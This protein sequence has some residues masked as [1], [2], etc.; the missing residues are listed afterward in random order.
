MPQTVHSKVEK[1]TTSGVFSQKMADYQLLVK[2][3]LNLWVVF[4]AVMGYLAAIGTNIDLG[5]LLLLAIGGFLVTGASN[6][7][8]QVLEREYDK[9]MKRTANRPL[10]AGRMSVTEAVFAA[11]WMSLVGIGCLSF[12]NPLTGFLGM[13]SLISYAFIYTPMKRM[14]PTAVAVGAFPGALPAAIG[15]VA[16]DGYLSQLAIL[17]FVVQFLW[18]FP[19]FWAIGWVGDEDYKN[20]GFNLMP[21][22]DGKL[23]ASIG[24]QSWAICLLMAVNAAIG[25]FLG[26]FGIF[27]T[28]VVAGMSLG[29]A[30]FGWK[31]QIEKSRKAA[32]GQMF[33]SFVY[34]PV[35]LIA[36]Y[37]DKIF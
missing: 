3:K 9:Q 31:L 16:V 32:L 7:L 8:N 18:Q 27:S 28:I 30:Y 4:S 13:V 34:L 15:A 35:V 19:H 33:A 5:Q 6:A 17:L 21:S 24:Q 14:S 23:D 26:E 22:K 37:L 2:M 12:F 20:A 25:W 29:F 10:A 11:G 36:I 1:T